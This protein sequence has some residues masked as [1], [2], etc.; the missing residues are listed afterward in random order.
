MALNKNQV[1]DNLNTLYISEDTGVSSAIS[2]LLMAIGGDPSNLTDN[3]KVRAIA[4]QVSRLL[5][6]AQYDGT[7]RVFMVLDHYNHKNSMILSFASHQEADSF[8]TSEYLP[9]VCRIQYLNPDQVVFEIREVLQ[10]HGN[11]VATSSWIRHNMDQA[12]NQYNAL[13]DSD[14]L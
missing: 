8:L 7:H 10:G 4:N 11:A 2:K 13:M 3:E 6:P 5:D 9:K 14:V 1:A 12:I